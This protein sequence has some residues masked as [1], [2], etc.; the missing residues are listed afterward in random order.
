MKQWLEHYINEGVDHFYLIDNGSNDNYHNILKPYIEKGLVDLVIDGKKHMQVSH[1]NNYFLKK[2]NESKWFIVCDFDELIYSRNRYNKIS[3][4]LKDL[5]DNI[6]MITIP[7]KLFGSNNYI[8]QPDNVIK[9]FNRRA[10][11][12]SIRIN[13][14]MKDC[15]CS[16]NK[17]IVNSNALIRFGMHHHIIQKNFNIINSNNEQVNPNS[18][19]NFSMINEKILDKS[20]LHL[21]HYAIQSFNWFKNIKCTRGDAANDKIQRDEKYFKDFDS[22]SN[23]KLDNELYKKTIK[24]KYLIFTN[25]KKDYTFPKLSP[26]KR[27]ID[28]DFDNNGHQGLFNKIIY[29]SGVVR[30]CKKNKD[31]VLIEPRYKIGVNHHSLG[32]PIDF[33]GIFDIYFFNK[34]MEKHNFRLITRSEIDKY[35]KNNKDKIIIENLNHDY[36]NIYGWN[37]EH[38]EYIYPAVELKTLS[39]YDNILLDV[40]K[41]LKL[42]KNNLELLNNII[43]KKDYNAIHMRIEKDWPNGWEKYNSDEIIKMLAECKLIE[44]KNIFFSVGNNHSKVN[45]NL[46]KHYGEN[47]YFEDNTMPYDLKSA[48]SYMICLLSDS[49]ISHTYSTFSSL[50]TMQRELQFLNSNNYYY[51]SGSI[52]TRKDKGLMYKKVKG[53]CNSS[54]GSL[55]INIINEK[56]NSYYTDYGI[57]SLLKNEQFIGT[58]FRKGGYWDLKNL[59]FL[60][61]YINPNKNILEIGGHC[62][63]STLV[64]QSFLSEKNKVFVYEPQKM[65]FYI[66]K[67]NIY[68]NN[69][70]NKVIP[71]NKGVFCINGELELSS[72]DDVNSRDLK[73]SNKNESF[74]NYGGVEVGKGGEKINVTTIDNMNH[75]NIGFIHCDAEGSESFIFSM[76]L[77]TLSKNRPVIYFENSKKYNQEKFNNIINNYP[78]YKKEGNF[79]LVNY[80][81]K[82]L[83][84]SKVIKI[85]TCDDLLLP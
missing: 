50:I 58:I 16:L 67:K 49:F 51:N 4:Y 56:I 76:S 71:F 11:Y 83:K 7:W 63:T 78:N 79:D 41:S 25:E 81:I 10:I 77:N 32:K 84:Y 65:M 73:I 59:L 46:S 39:I 69:L 85:G 62:G 29:L 34:H 55:E 60:K 64:Y 66:L 36:A 12:D 14:G 37:I 52:K 15:N 44:K 48:L 72:S 20:N 61:K 27:Y 57:V 53:E 8:N 3:D 45:N 1:Y 2:K 54:Q 23:E 42:T 13:Q 31:V 24:N 18:D 5:N 82:K 30:Y 22:C 70:H 47:F 68:Q 38:Q 80:C 21:N 26:K 75:D 74:C 43:N 9:H 28:I 6:G 33:S 19:I 17:S 40:M 35:N